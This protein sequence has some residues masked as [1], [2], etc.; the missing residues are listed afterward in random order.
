MFY[1]LIK[2][3]FSESNVLQ[4]QYELA[5]NT[6]FQNWNYQLEAYTVQEWVQ[7]CLV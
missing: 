3:L 5:G 4:I 2:T 7:F 6:K 1:I